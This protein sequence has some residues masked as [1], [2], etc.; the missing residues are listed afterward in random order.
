MDQRYNRASVVS[1]DQLC[2]GGKTPEYA[3]FF[4]VAYCW[5]SDLL[6]SLLPEDIRPQDDL[7]GDSEHSFYIDYFNQNGLSKIGY[8]K[9]RNYLWK[10]YLFAKNPAYMEVS[11]IDKELI[12]IMIRKLGELRDFHS[13]Y[14]YDNSCFECE[15]ILAK[16]IGGLYLYA[17]DVL[18]RENQHE[19]N[20]Y[21][22][23]KLAGPVVKRVRNKNMIT[24]HGVNFLLSLFLKKTDMLRFLQYC[25]D[26]KRSDHPE[27]RVR[28]KLY[29][30][31]THSNDAC[32]EHFSIE[33][34]AFS[35]V[36]TS[37]KE[38]VRKAHQIYKMVSYL[39]D[40]PVEMVDRQLFPLIDDGNMV[41]STEQLVAFILKNGLL[42]KCNVAPV[43][44]KND[45]VVLNEVLLTYGEESYEFAFRLNDL[46][47]LLLDVMRDPTREYAFYAD[48]ERYIAYR[49]EF[50]EVLDRFIAGEEVLDEMMDYYHFKLAAND[51]VTGKLWEVIKTV[52]AHRRL[53][54]GVREELCELVAERPII[55]H[56]LMCYADQDWKPGT[57]NEFMGFA[58]KYLMDL[59]LTPDWEW[60]CESLEPEV[61]TFEDDDEGATKEVIKREKVFATA[62]PDGY[63]LNM[64]NNHVVVRLKKWPD[65]LFSFGENA[66]RNLIFGYLDGKRDVDVLG[67]LYDDIER[68]TSWTGS[69]DT[70][71]FS[72]LKLLN[73]K[74]VPRYLK[75]MMRDE[76]VME[77][78]QDCKTEAKAQERMTRLIDYF[79]DI[80]SGAVVLNFEEKNVQLMRCY[81]FFNWRYDH[82]AEFKFL[83]KNEYQS[84]SLYHHALASADVAK[85]SGSGG[86]KPPKRSDFNTMKHRLLKDVML[87]MPEEILRL[88]NKTISFEYLFRAVLDETI[89]LL[90]DWKSRLGKMNRQQKRLRLSKLGINFAAIPFPDASIRYNLEQMRNIPFL[91]HPATVMQAM[92]YDQSSDHFKRFRDD[93]TRSEGLLD[94]SYDY[95]PYLEKFYKDTPMWRKLK[96]KIIGKVNNRRT[97]DVLILNMIKHYL[98]GVDSAIVHELAGELLDKY[99]ESF[100]LASLHDIEIPVFGG[101]TWVTGGAVEGADG[102]DGANGSGSGRLYEV[103]VK[104]KQL[105]YFMLM[106]ERSMRMLVRH[107]FCRFSDDDLSAKADVEVSDGKY[108]IPFGAIH[109]EQKRIFDESLKM[110]ELLLEKEMRIVNGMDIRLKDEMECEAL[111]RG[112]KVCMDFPM[113]CDAAGWTDQEVQLLT[114]IRHCAFCGKVSNDFSYRELMK[115][116]EFMELMDITP[117][118]LGKDDNSDA[119]VDSSTAKVF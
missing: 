19:V 32:Y 41:E 77:N 82:S 53:K 106:E 11:E 109:D 1:R 88:L 116:P 40:V 67:R 27:F 2:F 103:V 93:A 58:V 113:V 63:Q 18:A 30:F 104:F 70:M 85:R 36:K 102:V 86:R 48:L 91:I 16:R 13:N 94:E 99:D 25:N 75:L 3:V 35:S 80:K 33:P 42:M 90:E 14:W 50:P 39:R 69:G 9:L 111:S 12:H 84:M 81:K 49:N 22:D 24:Q 17:V 76:V 65:L 112:E 6:R 98:L 4:N 28:Q 107:L 55:W 20:V 62:V 31:Y 117:D 83:R 51:F 46:H 72:E 74:T 45:E 29:L 38:D 43:Y 26:F 54:R 21:R 56:Y 87:H 61:V 119:L 8:L 52:G 118:N 92:G 78:E 97:Q 110:T 7:S 15:D 95:E 34:T 66:M 59:K 100:M 60:L 114:M 5:I 10:G 37:T 105:H 101:M 47:K 89:D 79:K 96:H 57:T 44:N 71:P 115:D 73:E 23:S 68:I 64:K 108:T